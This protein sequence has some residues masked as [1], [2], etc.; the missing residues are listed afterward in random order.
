MINMAKIYAGTVPSL[1]TIPISNLSYKQHVYNADTVSFESNKYLGNGTDIRVI[2]N[3]PTFGG[4][5]NDLDKSLGIYSYECIDYT[6]L[7]RGKVKQTFIKKSSS[8]ILKTILKDRNLQTGGIKTTKKK[9]DELIFKDVKAIDLCHQIVNLQK[10]H[11]EFY[12]NSNGIGVFKKKPQTYKGIVLRPGHYK[13]YSINIDTSN[14]IT[15]VKVY[16]KKDA[17]KLLYSYNNKNLSAKYGV[18]TELIIDEKITTKTK[19]KSKAKA[20]FKKEGKSEIEAVITIP[21]IA[22]Y[23]Y[24]KPGDWII[25]YDNKNNMRSFFIEEI[26]NTSTTRKLKL[27]SSTTPQPDSWTYK[28]PSD[29]NSSCASNVKTISPPKKVKGSCKFCKSLPAQKN[30]FEN[31]CPICKKKGKMKFNYGH[32]KKYNYSVHD[33][34][35]GQFTCDPKQGGCGADYC[36]KCGSEKMK[37]KRG[38]MKKASGSSTCSVS[39]VHK[40]I[41]AKAKSLKSACKIFKWIK[42]NVKYDYYKNNKYSAYQVFTKKKGNCADQSRLLIA[43]LKCIGITGTRK[44]TTCPFRGGRVGHYNVKAKVNGM[45]RIIDPVSSNPANKH[46]G[47][48]VRNSSC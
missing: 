45:S 4:K 8:Q 6:D 10:D 30:T 3:F 43:M 36:A 15:G 7:L 17:K 26:T 13:D 37:K 38:T 16:G 28:K 40:D 39:G 25:V 12:V 44:H 35:E 41:V 42:S 31:K 29:S 2:G 23:K 34:P 19:A 21:A 11:Y 18:I 22:D 1:T 24:L 32:N 47:A 46:K 27:M 48:W 5:V 14:I 20:L 33:A 9:H